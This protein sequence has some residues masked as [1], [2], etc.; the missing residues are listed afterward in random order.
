MTF[1]LCGVEVTIQFYF[2]LILTLFTCMDRTGVISVMLLA[3]LLHE[4]GHILV[5]LFNRLPIKRAVFGPFGI[6][7]SLGKSRIPSYSGELAVYAAGPVSNLLT[8]ALINL[9]PVKSPAVMLFIA[10]NCAIAA[11]NLLP[12]RGLDGGNMLS[13]AMG[14]I[15]RSGTVDTIVDVISLALLVALLA[16]ACCQV[17]WSRPNLTLIVTCVYLAVMIFSGSSVK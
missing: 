7:L 17:F 12:I 15:S 2:F 10:A 1:F 4:G 3:V 14:G 16:V 8:A 6:R 9:L 13:A 11:F 5:I